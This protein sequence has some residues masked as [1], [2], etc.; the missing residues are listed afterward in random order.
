MALEEMKLGA[1]PSVAIR[2]V[3]PEDLAE[4]TGHCDD[5]RTAGD[6]LEGYLEVLADS[7]LGLKIMVVFEG[8]SLLQPPS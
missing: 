1:K 3:L 6:V 5:V 2:I 8:L 4:R 7:L